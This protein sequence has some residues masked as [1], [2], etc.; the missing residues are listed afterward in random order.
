MTRFY[1]G[2][3]TIE[4]EMEET[5]AIQKEKKKLPERNPE[6][7]AAH[8]RS[9]AWQVMVPFLFFVLVF[10]G[11]ATAVSI[12]A[13]NGSS[14]LRRWADVALISQLPLPILLALICLVANVGMLYGLIRL[15]GVMPGVARLVHNYVL[16]AQMKINALSDRIV[17]PFIKNSA[18]QAKIKAGWR[19]FRHK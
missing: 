15:V 3:A 11:M 8:R 16:L 18:A 13:V 17:E 12:A 2:Y 4:G 6:T 5:A 14:D 10:V 1:E 19:A 7:H 9:F